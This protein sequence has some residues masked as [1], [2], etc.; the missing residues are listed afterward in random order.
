MNIETELSRVAN[1]INDGLKEAFPPNDPDFSELQNAELYSLLAGGK[2]IRSFLILKSCSFFGGTEEA[3]L[4]LAIAI[5]M[6]QTYSLIHDDLPSMDNDDLRRGK[7]TCHKKF[8]EGTALLAGDALLTRAFETIA[9][10]SSLSFKA[11]VYATQ[12]LARA[13]G[14]TGMLAGQM[15]DLSAEHT[16]TS[17]EKLIKLQEHKTG[18]LIRAAC[19]LGAVAADLLPSE[20]DP[21]LK[22]LLV[23][24][25]RI[26]LAFQVIDDILDRMGEE[27]LLGKKIGSDAEQ[28]KTTFLSFMCV[29]EA[30]HF[31]TQLTEQAINKISEFDT[32][33]DLTALA[34][35]LLDRKH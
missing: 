26:G 19:L 21:R 5:E 33:G 18:A 15:M 20:A 25:D 14:D 27:S 4:P 23:Y 2:R 17:I 34:Y 6:I 35:Y 8:G 22:A 10:A 9:S 28:G 24:A 11:R 31:A 32:A 1:L 16:P 13:A 7:P 3:A 30:E 12:I 29:E